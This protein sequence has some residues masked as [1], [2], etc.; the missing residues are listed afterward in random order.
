MIGLKWIYRTKVN[1]DGSVNKLK[2]RLIVKRYAQWP[3]IDFSDTFAAVARHDTIRFLMALAA[4]LK[5]KIFTL[6]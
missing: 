5:W 2:A 3:G 4:K 1:L 6:M